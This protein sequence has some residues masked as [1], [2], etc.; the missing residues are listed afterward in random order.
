MD[1][2]A[3]GHFALLM[4]AKPLQIAAWLLLT[5][6]RNV[7]TPYPMVPSPLTFY[8]IPFSHSTSRYRRQTDGRH[9]IPIA[10]RPKKWNAAALCVCMCD[11][12][13]V[14]HVCCWYCQDQTPSQPGSESLVRLIRRLPRNRRPHR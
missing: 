10:Q 9:I 6:Y 1:T 14:V 2:Y 3:G 7:P 13:A 11:C 4:A 12:V 5:A 8:D